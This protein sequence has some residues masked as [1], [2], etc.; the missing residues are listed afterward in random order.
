M[1]EYVSKPIAPDH[2]QAVLERTFERSAQRST[3]SPVLR[4]T[5]AEAPA[6]PIWDIDHLSSLIGDDP[7]FL[8]E[9]IAVFIETM[10]TQVRLLASAPPTGTSQI[11][12]AIKGACANF[13]AHRL[14]AAASALEANAR[15]GS[16]GPTDLTSLIAV[17]NETQ[18]IV[19]LYAASMTARQTG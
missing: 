15:S 8:T 18:E 14:A 16:I 9:L 3:T 10:T 12:H 13:H 7:A 4:T 1:D 5:G 6:A 19:R 11:A 17:W 2:L